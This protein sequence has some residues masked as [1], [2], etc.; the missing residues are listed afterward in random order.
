MEWCVASATQC[1]VLGVRAV[2]ISGQLDDAPASGGSGASSFEVLDAS[3]G[4]LS[5]DSASSD[6][7]ADDADATGGGAKAASEPGTVLQ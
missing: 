1:Q 6:S 2:P 3:M 7:A 5:L 4:V